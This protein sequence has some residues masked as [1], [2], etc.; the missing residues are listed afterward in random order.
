M[1]MLRAPNCDRAPNPRIGDARVLRRIRAIGDGDT[2]QQRERLLDERVRLS[3][4]QAVGPKT[5]DGVRQIERRPA[6]VAR[7][8]DDRRQRSR[9]RILALRR[10][11]CRR[12]GATARDEQ[13]QFAADN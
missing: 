8:G 1:R 4:R 7:D 5:R 11:P 9:Q 12:A 13:R 10:A 3:G 6:D 2:G